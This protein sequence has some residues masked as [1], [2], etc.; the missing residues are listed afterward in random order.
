MV[1]LVKRVKKLEKKVADRAQTS[2]LDDRV[3]YES[4]AEEL[5]EAMAI[6]VKCG[7]VRRVDTIGPSGSC[8]ATPNSAW[9]F[10]TSSPVYR[11]STISPIVFVD[12]TSVAFHRL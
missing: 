5:A 3:I 8:L 4:G 10:G 9:N 6:L 11:G 12:L 2:R 1:A 7:A